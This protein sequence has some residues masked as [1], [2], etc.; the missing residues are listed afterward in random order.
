MAAEPPI[1]YDAT[2]EKPHDAVSPQGVD[3]Q[4]LYGDASSLPFHGDAATDAHDAAAQPHD[5]ELRA[6]PRNDTLSLLTFIPLPKAR[7]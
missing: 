6:T 1:R 2:A 3:S 7:P 4:P 5:G